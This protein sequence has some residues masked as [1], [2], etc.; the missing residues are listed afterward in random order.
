MGPVVSEQVGRDGTHLVL[1]LFRH[2]TVSF[3]VV[4]ASIRASP[5]WKER[6]RDQRYRLDSYA[7]F[8]M[9]FDS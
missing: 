2:N 8:K 5:H 7:N 1:P 9:V 6:A 4:W 3:P